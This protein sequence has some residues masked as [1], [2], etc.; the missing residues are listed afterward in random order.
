MGLSCDHEEGIRRAGVL[1]AEH[2]NEEQRQE[3]ERSGTITVVRRGPIKAMLVRLVLFVILAA[4]VGAGFALQGSPATTVFMAVEIL[5][6]LPVLA[7]PFVIASTWRRTWKIDPDTG[8]ELL[9]RRKRVEFC[10]RIA[11]ELPRPDQILAYKNI[12][13]ANEGYF[14]R[15]ANLKFYARK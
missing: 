11:A 13:E 14:L 10:V 9:W 1:L 3:Y 7:P 15:K 5:V 8:P 6:F 4:G 2:L 12:I